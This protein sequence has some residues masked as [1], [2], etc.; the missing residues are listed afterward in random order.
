M[1]TLYHA[2][3]IK[4][5]IVRAEGGCTKGQGSIYIEDDPE[6]ETLKPLAR[7][8]A[9]RLVSADLLKLLRKLKRI[10]DKALVLKV[11]NPLLTESEREVR[12]NVVQWAE[13]IRQT[14][15]L[16]T[17]IEARLLTVTSQLIEQEFKQLS[18]KELAKMLRLTPLRETESVQEVL[19]EDRTE[20]LL[21]LLK[22]KFIVSAT[23]ELGLT[24][25]LMELNMDTLEVLFE[26]LLQIDSLE[27]LERWIAE[28]QPVEV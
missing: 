15:N 18:Y 4:V 17:Q 2:E 3:I 25:A 14:P 22:K 24:S 7:R 13:N 11:L 19:K 23:E 5:W 28:H 21:R 27:Q 12:R 20:M 10:D 8:S 26:Q 9:Q 6:L 16:D 1:S